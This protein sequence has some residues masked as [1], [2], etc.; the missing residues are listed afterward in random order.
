MQTAPVTMVGAA[1]FY[2]IIIV[3]FQ[4]SS[5]S[6]SSGNPMALLSIVGYA[7]YNSTRL[8]LNVFLGDMENSRYL[9]MLLD[10][11]Q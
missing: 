2:D 11:I 8:F 9:I 6:Q 10:F 3:Y 7:L 4:K 5:C 1:L